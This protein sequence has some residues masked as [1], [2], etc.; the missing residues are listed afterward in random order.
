VEYCVIYWDITVRNH[1]S[2]NFR[3]QNPDNPPFNNRRFSLP[4]LQ[5]NRKLF[6]NHLPF[7]L[8]PSSFMVRWWVLLVHCG[9]KIWQLFCEKKRINVSFW[10]LFCEKKGISVSFWQFFST[11]KINN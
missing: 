6:P 5:P 4:E 9:R 7:I 1:S 2:Q 8:H 10:Q 3:K 11:K